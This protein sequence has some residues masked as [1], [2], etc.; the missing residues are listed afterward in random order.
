MENK[1]NQNYCNILKEALDDSFVDDY[2]ILVKKD[3]HESQWGHELVVS[4]TLP[5]KAKYYV[6]VGNMPMTQENTIYIDDEGN[7]FEGDQKELWLELIIN[8]MHSIGY[9]DFGKNI[10]YTLYDLPDII[11]HIWNNDY[12]SI[13]I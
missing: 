10:Q 5:N 4:L 13:I 8:D 12:E 7:T 2:G 1:F 6:V 3:E 11:T 9:K